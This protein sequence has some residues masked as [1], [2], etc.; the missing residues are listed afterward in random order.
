[1]LVAMEGDYLVVCIGEFRTSSWMESVEVR[2]KR[3]V[4]V[5]DTMNGAWDHEDFQTRTNDNGS[6]AYGSFRMK[7]MLIN[8]LL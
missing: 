5:F 6:N 3:R 8:S 1:M 2:Y 4:S 7:I